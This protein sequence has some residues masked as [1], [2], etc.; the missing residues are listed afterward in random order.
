MHAITSSSTAAPGNQCGPE[1]T[2]YLEGERRCTRTPTQVAGAI[3]RFQHRGQRVQ[4]SVDA[5][6]RHPG[7]QP[8]DGTHEVRKARVPGEWPVQALPNVGVVRKVEPWRH[9]AYDL[10]RRAVEAHGATQHRPLLAKPATPQTMADDNFRLTI[11][12][13]C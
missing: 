9:H 13:Q 2:K 1:H 11:T 3:L 7:L 10:V 8:C 5:L 6:D 4:L 12:V